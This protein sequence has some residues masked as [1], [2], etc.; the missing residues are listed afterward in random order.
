ME[1][2]VGKHHIQVTREDIDNGIRGMSTCCPVALAICRTFEIDSAEQEIEVD[3]ECV[4]FPYE[5]L[6]VYFPDFK[7][8]T[9]VSKFVSLFDREELVL[10]FEFD[11]FIEIKEYDDGE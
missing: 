1:A 4:S 6:E 9:L 8:A 11:M 2:K 3:G 7:V 10:P 5:Y